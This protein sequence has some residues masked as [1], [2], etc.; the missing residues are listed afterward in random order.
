MNQ[1][2]PNRIV[3][4]RLLAEKLAS[5][6]GRPGLLVLALPR[7]GVP[8]AGE[9]ARALQAPLDVLIVRPVGA[10]SRPR[11]ALGAV[12]TGGRRGLTSAVI[13][14]TGL[15]PAAIDEA[16]ARESHE[17]DRRERIYRRGRPAPELRDRPIILIDDGIATGATMR[18]A[19][20]AL[21]AAGAGRIVVAAPVASRESY[22]ELR[23][24]VFG[25][26]TLNM[27]RNFSKIQ[28][29]YT[30]FAPTTDSEVQQLLDH[31]WCETTAV[32]PAAGLP[33]TDPD[34]SC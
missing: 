25:F 2:F 11:V 27:P 24:V 3:A 31:A 12:A 5:H 20:A 13:E 19:V 26:V 17:Q 9:V 32:K 28:E 29:F 7:G 21:R 23:E 34:S 1:V 30:D 16:A 15:T 22:L 10:S 8:V 6:S 14:I 33:T 18:R 4:G